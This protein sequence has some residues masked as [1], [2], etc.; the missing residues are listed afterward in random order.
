MVYPLWGAFPAC[1]DGAFDA[2]QG[3]LRSKSA[4]SSALEDRFVRT[5]GMPFVPLVAGLC[6]TVSNQALT[7][8]L[9]RIA[10]RQYRVGIIGLAISASRWL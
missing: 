3:R 5:K 7:D 4:S 6:L 9:S 10:D 8:L 2:E 1:L